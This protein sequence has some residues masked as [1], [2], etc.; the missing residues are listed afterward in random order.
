[1][2]PTITIALA[3][4]AQAAPAVAE[5]STWAMFIAFIST[6]AFLFWFSIIAIVIMAVLLEFEKEGWATTIFSLG[7]ALVLWTNRGSIFEF[8]TQ[9][10]GNTIGFI[11]SY[12]AAGIIWSFVK[13]RTYVKKK[14]GKFQELKE[15]FAKKYANDGGIADNWKAWVKF[16]NDQLSYG[17]RDSIYEHFSPEQVVQAIIP[18]AKAKKSLIVSWI[19][20]WPASLGATLLNNPFRRFFEWIYSLVSGIY[21]RITNSET[22]AM[23]VGIE[24]NEDGPKDKKILRG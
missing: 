1:M 5:L 20:Y 12:V 24:K 22:K 16:L 19:S 15:A 2:T 10:P 14:T 18:V 6:G 8:I 11:L 23:L 13:W 21:D 17:D 9:N 3:S 7:T 4:A